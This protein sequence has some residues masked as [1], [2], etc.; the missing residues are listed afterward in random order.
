MRAHVERAQFLDKV[1]GVV[2]LVGAERDGAR[3]IGKACVLQR[4]R[5]A[6]NGHWCDDNRTAGVDPEP[7]FITVP[8]GEPLGRK[9][10]DSAYCN[11]GSRHSVAGAN[12]VV[13]DASVRLRITEDRA[14]RQMRRRT[15]R[16]QCRRELV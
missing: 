4:R 3:A 8:A 2:T 6:D 5:R 13:A 1:S 14:V 16:E 12:I 9:A 15:Q 10:D 7:T 11:S